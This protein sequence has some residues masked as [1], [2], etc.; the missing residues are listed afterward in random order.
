MP[1]VR[2]PGKLKVYRIT[3]HAI[4]EIWLM[5]HQH[6]GFI[7]GNIL[8]GRVQVCGLSK[9]IINAT[10]PE[11]R[12]IAFDR[13]GL[14]RQDSDSPC[15][16]LVCHSI[17]IGES[18]MIPHHSPKAV[19]SFQISEDCGARRGVGCTFRRISEERNGYEIAGEQDKL[20]PQGIDDSD[21]GLNG[22]NRKIRIVVEVT[23]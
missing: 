6:R 1:S 12:T 21:G 11:A 23:E 5:H 9:H 17:G 19:R 8:Q 13:G 3:S 4:R 20:W 18:I 10:Q 2:V 16:Q 14:I 7:L 22:M 15:L